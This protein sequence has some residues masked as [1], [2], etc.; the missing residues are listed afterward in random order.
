MLIIAL[1][2]ICIISN[3]VLAIPLS[4]EYLINVSTT[5]LDFDSYIFQYEVTNINQQVGSSFTGLDG[6]MVQIPNSAIIT[7]ITNPVSYRGS[8]GYWFNPDWSDTTFYNATEA[9][10]LAGNNWLR[11]WGADPVSVYPIGSTAAFSFQADGVAIGISSAV[12]VTYWGNQTPLADYFTIPTGNYTAFSTS[13]IS[14]V[15]VAPV[16]EPSTMFLLGSVL[17]GIV[18]LEKRKKIVQNLFS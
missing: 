1:G 17:I 12:Q 11:W 9:P 4:G 2:M 10:L 14:P 8:P 15:A 13:L 18:I 5:Q 16:P 6:F 3:R 7:N